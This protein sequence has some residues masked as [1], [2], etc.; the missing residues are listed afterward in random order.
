MKKG[1]RLEKAEILEIA[2]QFIQ[3]VQSKTNAEK[4][5]GELFFSNNL[6]MVSFYRLTQSLNGYPDLITGTLCS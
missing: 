6:W 1:C 5:E 3:R 4:Q 2:V